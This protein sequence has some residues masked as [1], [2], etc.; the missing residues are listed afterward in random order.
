[1]FIEMARMRTSFSGMMKGIEMFGL[2]RLGER[3]EESMSKLVINFYFSWKMI[4]GL[5]L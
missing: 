4:L 1:M 3:A 2:D 5:L